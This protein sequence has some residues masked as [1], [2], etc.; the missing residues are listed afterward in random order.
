MGRINPTTSKAIFCM[1]KV[2]S[3]ELMTNDYL[4]SINLLGD[5]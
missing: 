1:E 2:L 5:F 4:P 3:F